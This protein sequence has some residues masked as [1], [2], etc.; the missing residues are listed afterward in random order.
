M[1]KWIFPLIIASVLLVVSVGCRKEPPATPAAP[2][3]VP[4]APAPEPVEEVEPPPAPPVVDTTPEP[5]D[6]ELV[7]AD[8]HA[9]GTGLIG[10]IYFDFDKYDLKDEA[11]DRLARNASF[12][13][14][15]SEFVLTIEGHCDERGTNDYNI[16]LGDRRANAARDYLVSLGVSGSRVKTLSYG[17]E[18]PTCTEHDEGCWSKNRRGEFHLTGRT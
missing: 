2:P 18:R 11:R 16:A 13:K 10:D 12:L 5:L 17:E 9:R 3:P 14:E 4:E 8:K 1:K 15:R 6:D 7:I